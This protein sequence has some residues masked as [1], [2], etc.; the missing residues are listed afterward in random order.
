MTAQAHIAILGRRMA[1]ALVGVAL[2]AAAGCT[3]LFPGQ[4]EPPNVYDLTP[5]SSF[6]EDLPKVDWQL[7]IDTPT[8]PAALNTPRIALQRDNL[9]VDYYSKTVWT[10]AAP[11]LVQ[12]L[13]IESFENTNKIVS[14][15][16]EDA[17]LR[18][19]FLLKTDLREFEAQ[20]DGAGPPTVNVRINAKLVKMPQRV[21]IA[22]ET[23]GYEIK[24]ES[25]TIPAVVAAFDHA[26]G[27]TLKRIVIWAIEAPGHVKA[28]GKTK[29]NY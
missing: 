10:D 15:G 12:R 28:T 8:A 6:P 9:V 25:D 13:L 17:S 2:V 1:A 24:A 3:Q 29:A 5:K 27:K 23:V 19:D 20:Y 7:V 4:G 14:V 26:L 21:I 11:E 16:R 18:A 22:G